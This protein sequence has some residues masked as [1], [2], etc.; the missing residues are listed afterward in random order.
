MNKRIPVTVALIGRTG[1]GKPTIANMLNDGDLTDESHFRIGDSAKGATDSINF[2]INE[3]FGIFD[4][5]GLGEDKH[6]TIEH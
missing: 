3:N 2:I 6:G 1:C 5:V 4:T